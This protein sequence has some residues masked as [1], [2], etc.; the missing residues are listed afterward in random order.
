MTSFDT[1]WQFARRS[2]P[3]APQPRLSA[4][5][6]PADAWRALVT[7]LA[8]RCAIAAKFNCTLSFDAQG[9]GALGMLLLQLAAA[10][11]AAA[12]RVKE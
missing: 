3:A 10:A 4:G 1:F 5:C 12:A 7:P 11:D 2:P 6:P 8:D 9:A